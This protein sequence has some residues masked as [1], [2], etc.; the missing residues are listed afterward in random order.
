MIIIGVD[1]GKTGA[2]A[3]IKDDTCEALWD[4]PCSDDGKVD[5]KALW[6]LCHAIKHL[7]QGEAYVYIENVHTMPK[8]GIASSGKFMRIFGN[9]EAVFTCSGFPMS[10]VE[11]R[12]WKGVFWPEK[13]E[14]L[15]QGKERSL[16]MARKLFP[17]KKS[18]LKLAKHHNRAEALLIAEFGRKQEDYA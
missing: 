18:E 16:T 15:K 7:T 3:V 12:V 2:I 5:V 14:S 8:Q 1:V 13:A 11:P 10:Y 17:E 6:G 4:M 9:I